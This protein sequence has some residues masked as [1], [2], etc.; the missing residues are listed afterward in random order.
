MNDQLIVLLQQAKAQWGIETVTAIRN[1]INEIGLIWQSTLVN[2]IGFSQDDT[3]DGNITFKMAEY[4]K[5][6]DEGV[7]GTNTTYNSPYQF[8]GNYKGTAMAIQ[9][10]ANSKNLNNWAVARSIQKKGLE[11]RRFYNSVIESRI[12]ELA[13][14]LEGAYRTYLDGLINR[15]QNP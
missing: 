3:L 9:E 4:G 5:F 12:P 15:Q 11:P 6:L 1:R 13:T 2:S 14:K 8:K 7:N 10:W